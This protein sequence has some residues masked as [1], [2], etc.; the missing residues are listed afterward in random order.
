MIQSMFT[1]ADT[2]D[3]ARVAL[4]T[5]QDETG[6]AGQHADSSDVESVDD[7]AQV[8]GLMGFADLI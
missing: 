8:E 4:P 6:S 3:Y 2:D 1:F 5:G 7:E